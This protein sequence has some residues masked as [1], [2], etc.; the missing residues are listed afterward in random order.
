MQGLVSRWRIAQNPLYFNGFGDFS[1]ERAIWQ[2]F[3]HVGEKLERNWREKYLFLPGEK[4]RFF[5][6]HVAHLEHKISSII[7]MDSPVA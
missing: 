7:S 5:K 2:V 3:L 6:D 4:R 1:L